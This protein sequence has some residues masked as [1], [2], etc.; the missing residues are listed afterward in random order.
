MYIDAQ[1]DAQMLFCVSS[2]HWVSGIGRA[3]RDSLT[4]NEGKGF[5][6]V[7]VHAKTDKVLG[8]HLVGPEVAEILQVL[9]LLPC[10]LPCLFCPSLCLTHSFKELL[11]TLLSHTHVRALLSAPS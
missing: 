7:V 11:L 2:S 6:K 5:I 3:L 1:C 9:R 10:L 4:E 8:I